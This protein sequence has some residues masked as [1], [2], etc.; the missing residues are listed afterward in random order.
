M[1]SR[2]GRAVAFALLSLALLEATGQAQLPAPSEAPTFPS[3]LDL[4]TV[5]VIV[6]DKSGNPVQGLTAADF[7]LSEEGKPQTISSFEAVVLPEFEAAASPMR[8]R[9]STNTPLPRPQQRRTFVLVFDDVHMAPERIVVA[10]RAVGDFVRGALRPGDQV[11]L[12]P[13]SGGAWWTAEIPEGAADLTAAMGRLQ[14]LRQVNAS[15][16][17]HISD[18]EAVQL[19]VRRDKEVMSQVAR[20]YYEHRI[21]LEPPGG[22]DRA[23]LQ[24]NP[25]LPLIQAKSTEVYQAALERKRVTLGILR[26]VAESLVSVKGRKSVIL[27]S[28]GFVH[29]PQLTEFRAVVRAGRQSNA[30][31]YFLD[32][33]GISAGPVAFDAEVA[34]FTDP[35][36]LNTMLNEDLVAAQGADSI[37]IDTGGFSLKNSNDLG[38]GLRRIANESRSYY[39]LGYLPTSASRDGKFHKIEVKVGR[40]DVQVRA[41]R[42]YYAP[43]EGEVTQPKRDS[44]SPVVRQ[45]LD[46]PYL[47]AGIPLRMTSYVLGAAAA[48]GKTAVLVVAEADP[49]AL[50]FEER[51]GRFNGALESYVLV[52]ARDSGENMSREKLIELS[53]PPE[54]KKQLERSWLPLVRDFELAPGVYQARVL[55]RDRQGGRVGTVRHEFSVPALGSFHTST[56]ILTDTLQPVP[57]WSRG[58]PPRPVPVAHRSFETGRSLYYLFEVYGARRDAAGETRVSAGYQVTNSQGTVIATQPAQPLAP[59][60]RGELAQMFS[61]SLQ[62]VTPGEYA[63]GL[64]V[65]DEVAGQR[66][67]VLDPFTVTGPVPG[68]TSSGPSA[69]PS[70][71]P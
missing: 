64:L 2:S 35:R 18:W 57:E 50:G 6:T 19:Y 36:D 61:V 37:A 33:R 20:R 21:I 71:R 22:A 3:Q 38:A 27:V 56:S 39:L 15:A 65:Q 68:A 58:N 9:V 16:T 29:E 55:L 28:E 26:R 44:L 63:I 53:L 5:D 12:V 60:P 52:S 54:I 59:G 45:A 24:V 10:R 70:G 8:S 23:D 31:I 14:G 25:G 62:G 32:A 7:V 11:T 47:G 17:D 34:E 48:P 4:V 13:T 49:A 66:L 69:S 40:P 42:G 67:E 1:N 41:R 51:G 46:S 30:A 43:K